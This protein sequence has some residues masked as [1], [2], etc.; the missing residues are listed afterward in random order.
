MRI[1]IFVISFFLIVLING[2]KYNLAPSKSFTDEYFGI[3]I[4]DDYR[5][6]EN[7]QDEQTIFWMKSQSDYTSSLLAKIPNRNYYL[8]KR[9]EFDKRQGYSISDLRITGNDKYFY[10][11]RNAGEKTAKLYYKEGFLGEEKLL[12][13]PS[14]F[15]SSLKNGTNIFI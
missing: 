10:L 9:L 13:D 14:S 12:Y 8:D 2:Q 15:I 4:V 11:K 6:L 7:L 1:K 5:N 3:K